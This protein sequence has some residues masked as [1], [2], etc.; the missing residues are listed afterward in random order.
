MTTSEPTLAWGVANLG[1]RAAQAMSNDADF[2]GDP[3][4]AWLGTQRAECPR[5]EREE[6]KQH[7]GAAEET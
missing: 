6:R 3:R 1:L 2:R 7:D 5:R 4:R